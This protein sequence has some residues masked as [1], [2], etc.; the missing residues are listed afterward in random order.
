VTYSGDTQLIK[1]SG[2][3]TGCKVGLNKLYDGAKG[4]GSIT[5]NMTA[6]FGTSVGVGARTYTRPTV[7]V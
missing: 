4:V 5:G 6:N 7:V 1:S 3:M 2:S